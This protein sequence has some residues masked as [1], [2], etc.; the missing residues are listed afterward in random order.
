MK[1]NLLSIVLSIVVII[2]IITNIDSCKK[3]QA[4]EDAYEAMNDTIKQYRN[5]YNQEVTKRQIVETYSVKQFLAMKTTDS[6]LLALQKEVSSFKKEL[7]KGGSVT[8][9]DNDTD[10]NTNNE[11]EVIGSDTIIINDTVWLY[12][13]YFTDINDKGKWIT[14]S[15]RASKDSIHSNIKV[16]NEYSI[17]LG[18]EK[19]G[20]FKRKPVATVTNKN[21]YTHT[22]NTVT[23]QVKAP[24]VKRIGIGVNTGY[25][26]IPAP[27]STIG[28]KLS[29]Y[30][31]IGVNYNLIYIK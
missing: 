5:K 20:L 18:T 15:I 12:P 28:F 17:I 27:I 25:G 16:H 2:L 31:G 29:P 11:T 10:V 26:V 22:N 9:I 24:A 14:G 4:K 6:F 23:Y 8:V 21:P 13:I 1:I 3:Q 30:V 19:D 7:K